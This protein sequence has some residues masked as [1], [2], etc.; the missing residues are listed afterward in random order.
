M[1]CWFTQCTGCGIL[2]YIN[3]TSIH[4][5]YRKAGYEYCHLQSCGPEALYEAFS[6][7]GIYKESQY[8]IGKEIQD[9]AKVDYRGMLGFVDHRFTLITC[10]PELRKYCRKNNV[11]ITYV[12]KY[13]DLKEGDVAI[14]LLKDTSDFRN[15][16]WICWPTQKTKIHNY[17]NESTVIVSIY[18]LSIVE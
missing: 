9:D 10:P 18:K 13:E 15:W 16:H 17:F 4:K 7:L 14:V 1:C 8:V 11:D 5:T 2:Y 3:E 6:E 12:D